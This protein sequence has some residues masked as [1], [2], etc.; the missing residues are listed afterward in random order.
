MSARIVNLTEQLVRGKAEEIL[1]EYPQNPYQNPYQ[2]VFS[3][4]YIREKITAQVVNR[5]RSY[6]VVLQDAENLPEEWHESVYSVAEREEMEKLIRDK[7][8]QFFHEEPTAASKHSQ[9]QTLPKTEP[10]HW[11]G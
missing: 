8:C 6:Y 2:R 7:V 1:A 11:F 3:R 5:C 10:S 4:A 9:L